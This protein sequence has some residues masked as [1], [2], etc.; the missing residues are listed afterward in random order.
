MAPVIQLSPPPPSPNSLANPGS[1]G[2]WPLKR[3]EREREREERERERERDPNC[4]SVCTQ[5][6]CSY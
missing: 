1:P 5:Q 2:K 6:W 3:T 4:S